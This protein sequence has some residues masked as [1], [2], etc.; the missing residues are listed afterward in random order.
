M[1]IHSQDT[2]VQ[3]D[4]AG[5]GTTQSHPQQPGGDTLAS[6]PQAGAT[7]ESLDSTPTEGAADDVTAAPLG[8]EEADAERAALPSIEGATQGPLD[9]ETMSMYPHQDLAME[10]PPDPVSYSGADTEADAASGDAQQ[11][12][13][14][15]EAESG[16][17]ADRVDSTTVVSSVDDSVDSADEE[18]VGQTAPLGTGPARDAMEP[19]AADSLI[20]NRYV[21]QH[22][23]HHGAERNLYRALAYNQQRCNVCGRLSGAEV[24]VCPTCGSP[25]TGQ[26]PAEFY[27]MAESYRPEALMQDPALMDLNLYHPNIVPVIDFFSADPLGLGKPRYYAVAEPRQGVRL[28]QL[29]MPRPG[30]QVL[31]WAIQLA[32][33]LDYLHSRGVV[34]AG[35]E[36]D[37]ILVQG[38]RASLASLQ[39]ARAAMSQG[40]E[41]S[42]LQSMDLARLAST[43]YEAYTGNHASM[44]PEGTLAMPAGTPEPVGAAFRAAIEPVQGA[45]RTISAAQWR[46]LLS[47]ALR[48]IDELE[49]PGKPVDFVSAA[50]TDVG[51]LRE[52]NQDSFGMAEFVQA[53]AERHTRVGF[54]MV[55]DGMGGHKG[56]EI[57]SALGVQAFSGE[58]VSRIISP[59]AANN[60][61]RTTPNNEAILEAMIRAVQAANDR[62]YKGRD[63]RRNDMGTTLVAAIVVGGKAFIVNVG[64]SRIYI[65][66]RPHTAAEVAAKDATRPLV[67]GTT[68]LSV[69]APLRSRDAALD[70]VDAEEGAAAQA[71]NDGESAPYSLT[72]I[73]VDHSLVQRLVELGQLEPEEAKV[74]PHRNFVYRSLGGPPPVEVDTFVRTLHPGD[75]LL[76]CSDGLN[77]MIEDSDIEGVLGTEPDP[78]AACRKL[79][80]LANGNGG[81]DNIT[82]IIVD[83]TDYLPLAEHPFALAN[84]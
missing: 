24:D 54:Y 42:E 12:A 74:H 84:S 15:P 6:S 18:P 17:D 50:L 32:D 29:S 37:D 35:A 61:E 7:D 47:V 8:S 33:V 68:P 46:D 63:T 4:L 43:I 25:L 49:R 20:D 66:S 31:N 39:N 58:A 79:I 28:S 82:V 10:T 83:V 57:A 59:L 5:G 56:G 77:S 75:R 48:A 60:N 69:T 21:V 55:S 13:A 27:L 72:Q 70:M 40:S 23:L 14:I 26:E 16:F 11:G 73:S 80:D 1:N 9:T 52:Q 22:V 45:G 78:H 3:E 81:H 34:G 2:E 67:K 53:S 44:N 62:I 64:D 76:L 65:Y 38:E 36:A 51:R 71:S 30:L 41:R 19:V